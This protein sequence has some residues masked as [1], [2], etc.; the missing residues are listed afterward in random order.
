LERIGAIIEWRWG[1][2]RGDRKEESRDEKEGSEDGPGESQ[3][4]ETPSS[5]SY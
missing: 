1:L 4:K 5:T 2:E 3:E